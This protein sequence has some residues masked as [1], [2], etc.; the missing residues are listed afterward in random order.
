LYVVVSFVLNDYISEAAETG[1]VKHGLM[2]VHQNALCKNI[3]MTD[4]K[5][6]NLVL[7]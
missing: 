2:L 5:L 1:V 3:S 7:H 6:H 4:S